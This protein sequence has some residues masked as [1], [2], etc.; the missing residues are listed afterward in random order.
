MDALSALTRLAEDMQ[1]RRSLEALLSLIAERAAEILGTRRVSVRLLNPTHTHLL[2][3]ARAGEPVHARHEE[4]RVGEGLLGHVAATGTVIRTNEPESHP[5]YVARASMSDKLGSFLGVPIRAGSQ[6]LG[7]LSAV[8]G[9]QTFTLEHERLLVLVA[10]LCAP[11]VEIARL[12]RLS[13]ADPLTGALNRRGLDEAL[14]ALDASA[15]TAP[16]SVVLADVDHFKTVNDRHGHAVGDLVLKHVTTILAGV[17]RSSDAVVRWGGEE[18]LLLLP[19]TA[20]AQAEHVAERARVSVR[21]TP[22]RMATGDV[23]V[24][25]SLGV[26]ARRASEPRE[27]LLGR[28]D[29]ALY[30]AKRGGRDR[31]VASR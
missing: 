9:S 29:E 23:V 17:V 7:V 15:P 2:G 21:M 26:A 10:A 20:L 6:V 28:A 30:R 4:F 25:L 5:K 16:L 11:Y 18:I 31:V 1:E 19:G 27:T 12:A 14:A 24:T 22:L 8:G 3:I 13:Q